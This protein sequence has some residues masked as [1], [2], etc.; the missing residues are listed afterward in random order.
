MAWTRRSSPQTTSRR[1]SSWTMSCSTS[2]WCLSPLVA[3]SPSS[4]TAA[5][6]G[7]LD[8]P[9]VW[10]EGAQNWETEDYPW[11]TAGDVQM[12]S[13]CE[14][15]QCSM[16]ASSHGRPAG[17]MTTAMCDVLERYANEP[18]GPSITCWAD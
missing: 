6:A 11:H 2:L 15:S 4:L 9:F 10:N 13:G 8:L 1:A 7:A 14:D 16:D 17:A 3:S 12:F 5:T 18:P